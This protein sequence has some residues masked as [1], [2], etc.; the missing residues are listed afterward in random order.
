MGLNVS[1]LCDTSLYQYV[2]LILILVQTALIAYQVIPLKK[3]YG[4]EGLDIPTD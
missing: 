2:I 1:D 4:Q 3:K